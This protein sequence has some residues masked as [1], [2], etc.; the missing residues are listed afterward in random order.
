MAKNF[1][2]TETAVGFRKIYKNAAVLVL[3][4]R[5]GVTWHGIIRVPGLKMTMVRYN[6]EGT[7]RERKISNLKLV[8]V[9]AKPKVDLPTED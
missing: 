9:K 3:T 2:E 4:E 5:P 8:P 7:L 6:E 1:V